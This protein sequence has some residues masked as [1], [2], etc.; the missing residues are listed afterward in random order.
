[1]TATKCQNC[2]TVLQPGS[3]FCP[4]CGKKVATA[5]KVATKKLEFSD[6]IKPTQPYKLPGKKLLTSG[7]LQELKDKTVRN[8]KLRKQTYFFM[9]LALVGVVVF[10]SIG[11]SKDRSYETQFNVPSPIAKDFYIPGHIL[12][13]IFFAMLILNL[14]LR[15]KIK[16]AFDALREAKISEQQLRAGVPIENIQEKDKKSEKYVGLDGWL[17][18]FILGLAISFGF[19]IYNTFSYKQLLSTDGLQGYKGTLSFIVG[20][21]VI[22]ACMQ[23]VSFILILKKKKLGRW[24]IIATLI[25]GI[26]IYAVI[27]NLLNRIYGQVGKSVP[28]QTT[29]D[30]SRDVFLSIVWA[31]YF[32]FSRRV[33]RT[34]VGD[35]SNNAQLV[36][37]R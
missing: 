36:A 24:L 5:S 16:K 35:I 12:L 10:Y 20:S 23:L 8:K 32:I 34:L 13:A 7:E 25:Y 18:W 30:I 37:E 26:V 28:Q 6:N 2:D 14:V 22:L 3:K 4:S 21:F 33:R 29:A 9:A 27:A 31:L 19:S 15:S 11:V 1:M 17:A